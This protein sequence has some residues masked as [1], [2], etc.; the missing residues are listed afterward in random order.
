MAS[1]VQLKLL[2]SS[3]QP[4]CDYAAQ[5]YASYCVIIDDMWVYLFVIASIFLLY[6][7][8]NFWPLFFGLLAMLNTISTRSCLANGKNG[9]ICSSRRIGPQG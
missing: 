6:A 3:L 8:R 4:K 2:R 1:I 9:W 7:G 5:A